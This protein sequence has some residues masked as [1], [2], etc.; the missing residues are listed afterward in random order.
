MALVS[1]SFILPNAFAQEAPETLERTPAEKEQLLN[2]L[3][4]PL[5]KSTRPMS[6][7][8]TT[9][10]NN[11][12]GIRCYSFFYAYGGIRNFCLRAGENEPMNS[13]TGD[14]FACVP[15]NYAPPSSCGRYY[16][17]YG[18]ETRCPC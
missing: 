16:M 14:T 2:D 11:S 8:R 18:N 13:Q 12:G 1:A 3:E 17:Y 9:F 7:G 6:S 4:A 15:Q 5:E 10:I